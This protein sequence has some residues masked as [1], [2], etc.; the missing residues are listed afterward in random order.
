MSA[1]IPDIGTLKQVVKINASIPWESIEPFINDA[2]DIY[3]EPQVGNV[4]VEIAEEG[5]DEELTGKMLRVLGPLCLSLATDELGV[6]FGDSGITVDN[7]QGKRSPANEAKIAAAKANLFFRGMQALDR[8][9]DY[10][11]RNKT[12]YPN[13]EDHLSAISSVPCL[14]RTAQEYQDIGLVNID[15]STLTYRT[16]LP[17]L[18]Q[19]QVRHLQELLPLELYSRLH[20]AE[21]STKESVLKELCIRYLA[22]RS[23]E[24]YTSQNSRTQRNANGT[25]PE[26]RPVIRPLYND[27]EDTGNFFGKQADY[28]AGKIAGFLTENAEELG[29]KPTAGAMD[30]NAKEHKLFTSIQ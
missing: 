28:Y 25:H 12:K 19:L 7:V 17:T 27:M 11:S 3:L 13:Y 23:A 1:I 22:N 2:L 24:L 29:V 18:R 15:Y 4:L 16:M 26:Y 9:L 10:L 14:I 30:Y 21:L 5:T 20:T 6:Q 8:L